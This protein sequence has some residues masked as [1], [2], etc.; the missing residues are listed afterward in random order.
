MRDSTEFKNWQNENKQLDRVRE[1]EYVQ[2]SNLYLFEYVSLPPPSN[3][4]N[5]DGAFA[6]GRHQ[7]HA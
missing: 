1:L 5:R 4:E 3:R 7:S 6:G 2:K